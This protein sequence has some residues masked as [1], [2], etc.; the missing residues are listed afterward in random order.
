MTSEL[1]QFVLAAIVRHSLSKAVVGL[2]CYISSEFE[3]LKRR[4]NKEERRGL[5]KISG[6]WSRVSLKD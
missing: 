1:S 6:K 3:R 5:H 4:K 2:S